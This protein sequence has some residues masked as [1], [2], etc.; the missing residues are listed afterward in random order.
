MTTGASISACVV[1]VHVACPQN[2]PRPRRTPFQARPPSASGGCR[3]S[4]PLKFCMAAAKQAK[5]AGGSVVKAIADPYHLLPPLQGISSR[6][7]RHVIPPTGPW[8]SYPLLDLSKRASAIKCSS[9]GGIR[10][11]Q[12]SSRRTSVSGAQ[13]CHSRHQAARGPPGCGGTHRMLQAPQHGCWAW[14]LSHGSRPLLN[15]AR[16]EGRRR[17]S[18]TGVEK[19]AD[20]G[21]MGVGSSKGVVTAAGQSVGR[22][23]GQSDVSVTAYSGCHLL[24]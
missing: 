23:M 2:H 6:R 5:Y 15:A 3:A 4:S 16:V 8:P 20:K 22:S 9:P 14:H 12:P 1:T 24:N 18:A 21:S 13:T 19:R 17:R 11:A 10:I 7:G